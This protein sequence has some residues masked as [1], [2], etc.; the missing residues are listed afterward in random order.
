MKKLFGILIASLILI[1]MGAVDDKKSL[2]PVFRMGITAVAAL[3]VVKFG[4]GLPKITNPL[5]GV[6]YLPAT[7]SGA[8][9]FVWL[10][11]M[12]YTTKILDGLDGLATGISAI[13]ALVL[14]FFTNVEK[15]FQPNVAM[16]AAIFAGSCLGFLI[17]NFNPAKIFLGEGGS[18]FVG[19]MLGVL[20]IIS[21]GKV[22]IALLVMAIPF[23]DLI[24]V[25]YTRFKKGQSVLK[26]DREHLHFRLVDMELSQRSVV[27]LLYLAALI[28]GIAA[29]YLQSLQ[30]IYALIFL[31]LAMICFHFF[32]SR[33]T[34]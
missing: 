1:V 28:F 9:V 17:F 29:L 12:M 7:I 16:L 15:Y 20:A 13:G 2:S 10:M 3:I 30:K 14:F 11:A 31:I 19:L 23:L 18:L 4:M 32:I 34:V 6:L 26:G 22:A 25:A 27:L 24:R 5:G 21:G 8:F 33:K